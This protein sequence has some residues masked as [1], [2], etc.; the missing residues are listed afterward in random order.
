MTNIKSVVLSTE[1]E[2]MPI[3]EHLDRI[4]DWLADET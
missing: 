4:F 1:T 3:I 2:N